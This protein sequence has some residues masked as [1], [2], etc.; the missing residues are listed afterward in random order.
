MYAEAIAEARRALELNYGSSTKGYLGLWLA[1]SGKRD[2][3]L[4]LL[5]ELRQE[6][7]QT[8]VQGDTIAFIYIGL[9]DKSEALNWLEKQMLSHAENANAYAVSPQFDELRD[10]PRFKAMLK[11]MNLPE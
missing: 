6:A 7:T 8:Y 2:E 5:G 4:K 1:R 11:Q 10:E 3:A 9:G